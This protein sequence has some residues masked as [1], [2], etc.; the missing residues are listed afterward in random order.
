[1]TKWDRKIIIGQAFDQAIER[2]LENAKSVIVLWSEH[3]IG[4]NG[5]RT[6]RQLPRSGVCW[7]P[8]RFR[9]SNYR[10]SFAVSTLPISLIGRGN[11]PTAVFKP[12]HL[13]LIAERNGRNRRILA[14]YR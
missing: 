10:L 5:S 1:M 12:A 13:E 4:P 6:R 14:W 9:A 3:S 8:P 11:L 7:Y 2:E